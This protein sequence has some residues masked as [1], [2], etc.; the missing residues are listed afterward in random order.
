[1]A[2][3]A[4]C[5]LLARPLADVAR[6]TGPRNAGP[7]SRP[8]QELPVLSTLLL[9]TG[10]V[11]LAEIGDKTQLLA[12]LL[13]ARFRR[14]APILAGI[15]VA[16]LLNHAVSA[17][18]G[19]WIGTHVPA[20]W[21]RV[22]TALAFLAV[23]AWALVPDHLDEDDAPARRTFGPFLTTAVA[24]FLAELGDKTQVA[25]VLLAATHPDLWAV[26]AG[27]TLGLLIANAPVVWLGARFADRLP[28]AW[29]R[30]AS[31][32][33]FAALGVWLLIWPSSTG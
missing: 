15:A 23:A 28:L 21:L 19:G 7:V 26:V 33:V 6:P 24:F 4:T 5:G 1:M 25:T 30:R 31:A 22:G 10:V 29:A 18:L 12:L 32:A 2:R 17:A 27:T 8:G 14:P 11:A 20:T 13:S 16:T 9:A 3:A